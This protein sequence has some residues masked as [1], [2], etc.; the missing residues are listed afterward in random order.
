MNLNF[1]SCLAILCC[2]AGTILSEALSTL[3]FRFDI[4]GKFYLVLSTICVDYT[5]TSHGQQL[6]F[7]A[8]FL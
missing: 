3:L 1:A 5:V 2:L 7:L 6:I 4:L 8:F